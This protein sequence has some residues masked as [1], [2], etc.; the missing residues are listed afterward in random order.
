MSL[1]RKIL[2][3][4]GITYSDLRNETYR[5]RFSEYLPWIAYEDR[6]STRL[7]SSH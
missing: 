1:W 2:G 7:N 4:P 5:K 3:I 6:K